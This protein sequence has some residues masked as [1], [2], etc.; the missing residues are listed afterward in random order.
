MPINVS[1]ALDSDTAII[2]TITRMVGSGYSDGVYNEGTESNFKT[3]ASIQQPSPQQLMTLSEGERK[4]NIRLVIS[5]KPLYVSDD[6]IQRPSDIILY[7]G[8]RYKVIQDGD[9]SDYGHSSVL[10]A[11]LQQ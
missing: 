6:R 4:Q 3:L 8:R 7:K 5:K 11:E 10:V 1:E 9:W 2:I